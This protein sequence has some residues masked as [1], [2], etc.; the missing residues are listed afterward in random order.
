MRPPADRAARGGDRIRHG[1][2]EMRPVLDLLR[3]EDSRLDALTYGGRSLEERLGTEYD[4]LTDD[5]RTAF[6]RLSMVETASFTP[7]VIRVLTPVSV[8][9]GD[10]VTTAD[11]ANLAAALAAAGL[12]DEV[13][14]DP[15]GFPR[16]AFHPLTRVFAGKRLVTLM[17]DPLDR[18]KVND[19]LRR[20]VLAACCKVLSVLED[21]PIGGEYGDVLLPEIN[22]WAERVAADVDHWISAELPHLVRAVEDAHLAS[23]GEACWLIAAW[24]DHWPE[25]L[26]DRD[27][28]RRAF[29]LAWQAAVGSGRQEAT[30][31]VLR[32]TERLLALRDYGDYRTVLMVLVTAAYEAGKA[33][34]EDLRQMVQLLID[35]VLDMWNED[36]GPDGRS[37]G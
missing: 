29:E 34:R 10:P 5:E 1:G 7:W 37:P 26:V 32:A 17:P 35:Q 11:A 13:S 20:A 24:L 21:R 23:D 22:G 18:E 16:Y 27:A 25:G 8:S 9:T 19:Q 14:A 36:G 30:S 15:S 2:G 3:P 31:R 28:V 6:C 33:G 4:R 12:L